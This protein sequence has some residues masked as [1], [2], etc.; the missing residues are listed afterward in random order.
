[1]PRCLAHTAA[2]SGSRTRRAE[3]NLRLSPMAAAWPTSGI[4]LSAASRLA[5]LMF[6]PPE[7]MISSFLR[8]TILR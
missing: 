2:L 5:G 7:V 6:L 1:M 4:V 3:T 8:S